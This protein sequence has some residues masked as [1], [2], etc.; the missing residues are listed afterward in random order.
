MRKPGF[1]FPFLAA[2]LSFFAITN[3]IVTGPPE[4]NDT[5]NSSLGTPQDQNAPLAPSNPGNAVPGMTP[6]GVTPPENVQRLDVVSNNPAQ[7]INSSTNQGGSTTENTTQG[8]VSNIVTGSNAGGINVSRVLENIKSATDPENTNGQNKIDI[9]EQNISVI[10]QDDNGDKWKKPCTDE[11]IST[12]SAEGEKVFYKCVNKL[13]NQMNCDGITT[14][15]MTTNTE[16]V[17]V[18]PN[19]PFKPKSEMKNN[20]TNSDDKPKVPCQVSGQSKC[21]PENASGYLVCSV[22]AFW[23]TQTCSEGNIC[24]VDKSGKVVCVPKNSK[25]AKQEP[26][27]VNGESR[28]VSGGK[29]TYQTCT[30]NVW[31]TFNCDGTNVCGM[32]DSKVIC[33]DPKN[34][35]QD[36]VLDPCESEGELRCFAPNPSV[37]QQCINK[38]WANMTCTSG[39]VC[40]A[41]LSKRTVGCFDPNA[42]DRSSNGTIIVSENPKSSSGLLTKQPA[43][44]F[45][46]I[47]LPLFL[48]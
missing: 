5:L 38:N 15:R 12:C 25:E 26:C 17:C 34:S 24:K 47:L 31:N 2:Y 9:P 20:Q 28:C 43:I 30:D 35:I 14:C 11:G 46:S 32:K 45:A 8:T 16:A 3:G 4:N 7:N 40:S 27:K 19:V 44:L 21:D 41:I 36:V 1:L 39:T 37:Y 23:E 22:D 13:W 18:D 6:T 33:Y 48:F 10:L 29:S 42:K